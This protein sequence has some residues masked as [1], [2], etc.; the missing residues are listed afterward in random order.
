MK[1]GKTEEMDVKGG[2][3]SASSMDK[4]KLHPVCPIEDDRIL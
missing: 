3:S 4:K 1:I 2:K